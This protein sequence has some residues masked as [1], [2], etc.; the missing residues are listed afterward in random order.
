M[1]RRRRRRRGGAKTEEQEE[2]L[3][4]RS[5]K[6]QYIDEITDVEGST[7]LRPRSSVAVT[8]AANV[9]AKASSWNR[10]SW[11]AASMWTV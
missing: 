5:R 7:D 1:T 11:L 10:I 6:Q 9:A 4:R 3:V 8:I 2:P